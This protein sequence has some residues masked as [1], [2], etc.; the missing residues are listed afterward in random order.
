MHEGR[1]GEAAQN[2]KLPIRFTLQINNAGVYAVSVRK[3]INADVI[4]RIIGFNR[5]KR[6]A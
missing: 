1:I 5:V 4:D 2:K 3:S 6:A